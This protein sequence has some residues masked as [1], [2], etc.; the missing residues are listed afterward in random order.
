[1]R[2]RVFPV[3]LCGFTVQALEGG[4]DPRDAKPP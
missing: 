4:V 1:M 3:P 2:N